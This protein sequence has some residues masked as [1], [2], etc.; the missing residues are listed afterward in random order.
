MKIVN[1]KQG[2]PEWLA[3][4][5][6]FNNASDAPAMMGC[7]PYKTR[8]QLLAERHSGMVAEVDEG[9]QRRFDDGHRVEALYR[10][11]AEAIIGE[12]LY[13]VTGV[14]GKLSAS[15]DGL[16]ML[17]DQNFE[18]KALNDALRAAFADME[19]IAPEHREKASGK[20]LPLVF[21]VQMEQQHMVSGCMRTLFAAS[22]WND[23][24]ELIEEKWCWY[25]SD[26]A[27]AAQIRAGWLQ[28]DADLA[29]YVPPSAAASAPTGKAPDLLP[30]LRVEVTGAVTASNL[31]EFK[32][33][34]L[35]AIRSVNREL[36]SDQ[37]FADADKAVKWC[38]DVEDRLAAAKQH[39]LSQTESIEVLFRT[40]DE[41]SN[42]ARQV[43]L[44]LE[45][46]V[47]ARKDARKGEIVA[48]GQ[49]ALDSH[50]EGLNARLGTPWLTRR[51][52]S[53]GETVK[54]KKSFKSM[55]DAVDAALAN[56]KVAA[57]ALADR[58][59]Q[60]RKALVVGEVDYMFLFADFAQQGA[61]EP[62]DFSAISAQRVQQHL[63]ALRAAQAPAPT[64]APVEPVVQDPP[65]V[66]DRAGD[67]FAEPHMRAEPVLDVAAMPPAAEVFTHA[68][69]EPATEPATLKLG[70][71]CERFG[72]GFSIT[73]AFVSDT[74]GIQPA[75]TDRAAKLYRTSDF[76]RI[77]DAL[78]AHI[79][80]VRGVA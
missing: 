15:F 28:F 14:S 11:R 50:V 24:D 6:Q 25:Y 58:L 8:A 34:A 70:T 77:C 54:G 55:Q 27:L 62:A 40:M 72:P 60:N 31:A 30:A 79:G 71:I 48:D 3:H 33:T 23:R 75:G 17:G 57:S 4:R 80:S 56:E 26:P 53:F 61:K 74:L 39:A 12:E 47:K 21:R 22:K 1:V 69:P 7:S 38:G 41:I 46:L 13:P 59:E 36:K 78:V 10:P 73:A 52:G 18:H 64:P 45:K 37:D 67:E 44:D 35:Q 66:F 43:R 76:A 9:T 32:A 16:T 65:P 49:V 63:E 42:E 20:C 68:A 51:V 5:R 2:S 19:T 29:A